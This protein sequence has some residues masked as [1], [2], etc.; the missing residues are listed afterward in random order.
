MPARI[1]WLSTDRLRRSVRKQW[2]ADPGL[3]RARFGGREASSEVGCY[4]GVLESVH[5]Q[6]ACKGFCRQ[7]ESMHGCQKRTTI[8]QEGWPKR[9]LQSDKVSA[10][11]YKDYC[12]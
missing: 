12:R 6:G 1:Q 5:F 10:T 3:L 4:G 8:Y 7:G 9:E 11:R 2:E